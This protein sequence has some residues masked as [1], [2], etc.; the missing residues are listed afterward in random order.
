MM[1]SLTNNLRSVGLALGCVLLS[2]VPLRAAN[3]D[4]DR[5][6][7]QIAALQ[8]QLAEIQRTGDETRG[9]I[10]RLAELVA[11]QNALLRKAAADGRTTNEALATSMKELTERVSEL[12]EALQAIKATFPLPPAG[13]SAAVTDP[14]A[15]AAG[16]P[17]AAAPG[18]PVAGSSVPAPTAPPPAPREL[19]SQ[20]YADYARG[21]YDLA[22]QGFGEYLKA[23]PTTDFSDNA[24]YWIGECLYGKKMY[25]EAIEAWNTL[26][27]DYPTSDKLADA[28]VK[29]GMS[30]E[31]LGRRSQALVEYRY[32]VDRYPTSQAARI[33]RERLNP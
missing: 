14:N 21:N 33:A 22:M 29:K 6:A 26:L 24:Q 11:E 19:Y 13:P 25:A 2:A 18:G 7:V 1:A 3:K 32:V 15:A 10:K 27:K 9:E 12:S 4:I 28:R 30:L 8:G 17:T 16:G 20:A 31:R 23:Y 5:L